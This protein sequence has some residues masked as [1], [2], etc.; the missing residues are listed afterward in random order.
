MS[1]TRKSGRRPTPTAL[2]RLHGARVR[3]DPAREPQGEPGRPAMP[4]YFVDDALAVAAWERYASTLVDLKVL[5]TAHQLPHAL[6]AETVA[7]LERMHEEWRLMGRKSVLVTEWKDAEGV[8][9]HRIIANP[10]KRLYRAERLLALQLASE[11]G[12]TPATANKVLTHEGETDP[13]FDAFLKGPK[14]GA[15]VPFARPR[16]R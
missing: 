9:R 13:E 10:L 4:A 1:G 12:L 16:K 15:V 3:H 8:T 5:T 7:D 2:K 14:V 6:L 11:F